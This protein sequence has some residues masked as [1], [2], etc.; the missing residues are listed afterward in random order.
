VFRRGL[1]IA[2][3]AAAAFSLATAAA[4][5]ATVHPEAFPP[6]DSGLSF[7][8]YGT[9]AD[10]EVRVSLGIYPQPHH[11][12]DPAGVIG[13]VGDC[14]SSSP[15]EADC[16]AYDGRYLGRL[17][18]GNDDALMQ[19]NRH[20]KLYG[21][22]GL[23]Y[24]RGSGGDEEIYGGGDTDRLDGGEG[25]DLIDGGRG[26]DSLSGGINS[27]KIRADDG[28]ADIR[29]DCGPGSDDVARIDRKID[30]RPWGCERVVRVR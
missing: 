9:T 22:D 20:G 4:S 10:D 11:I 29:I 16:L 2:I 17:R 27:D 28:I 15:T 5:T 12:Q 14:Q 1:Q 24:L 18:A 26:D 23:D 8:F 21:G 30:D 13:A 25:A 19:G 7:A 3:V 6:R